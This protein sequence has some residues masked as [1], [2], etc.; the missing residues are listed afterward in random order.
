MTDEPASNVVA[1]RRPRAAQPA[2][3]PNGLLEAVY[4][5]GSLPVEDVG[6]KTA[7]LMLQALGFLLVE[8][9]LP[10]GTA[11]RL[12]GR[13]AKAALHRPWRLSKPAFAGK[14]GEPDALGVLASGGLRVR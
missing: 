11:R 13:E 8:E 4:A 2:R 6:T 14:P 9:V 12:S 1:F 5:A 3:H 10:D 7:A